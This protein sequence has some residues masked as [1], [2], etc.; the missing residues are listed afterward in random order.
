MKLEEQ[1]HEKL[2]F[3]GVR[4]SQPV[5]SSA[6]PSQRATGKS[7]FVAAAIMLQPYR[8]HRHFLIL[9]PIVHGSPAAAAASEEH[10]ISG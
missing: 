3:R 6:T 10:T 7:G 4:F 1:P 8:G 9:N 5:T 2:I